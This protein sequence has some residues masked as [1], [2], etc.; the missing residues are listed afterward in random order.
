M[1][2]KSYG[3]TN[4]VLYQT[5][6]FKLCLFTPISLAIILSGL[7]CKQNEVSQSLTIENIALLLE[8]FQLPMILVGLTVPL[9]ALSA[10]IH[11]SE[12]TAIQIR[13][14]TEQNN[15]ANHFKHLEEFKSAF[16]EQVPKPWNSIEDFHRYIYPDTISGSVSPRFIDIEANQLLKHLLFKAER[17]PLKLLKITRSVFE[18]ISESL[19]PL[20]S[21]KGKRQDIE[22][23]DIINLL[24]DIQKAYTFSGL[25]PTP[26][27]INEQLSKQVYK[28]QQL[29]EVYR[30]YAA[31]SK[32][33]IDKISDDSERDAEIKLAD[34]LSVNKVYAPLAAAYAWIDYERKN[35]NDTPS[36]LHWLQVRLPDITTARLSHFDKSWKTFLNSN[37]DANQAI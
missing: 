35:P 1:W 14:Q 2:S 18:E 33:V 8:L 6:L 10:A 22:P 32:M 26:Y 12:Q 21:R 4:V 37:F 34:T 16:G 9:T 17:D 19:F 20:S 23:I 30:S 15:F 25:H 3:K 27:K 5:L 7:I 13:A 36:P 29:A 24:L 28:L 31:N 11:R